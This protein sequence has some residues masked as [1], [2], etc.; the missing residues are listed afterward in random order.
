[1]TSNIYW[2]WGLVA[3]SKGREKCLLAPEKSEMGVLCAFVRD[4][5][6]FGPRGGTFRKIIARSS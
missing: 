2:R 4:A 5:V 6:V 1:M 3:T